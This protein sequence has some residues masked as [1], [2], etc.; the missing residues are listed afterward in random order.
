MVDTIYTIEQ[1]AD[2][3]HIKP[4][5]LREWIRQEKVKAFKLGGLVR[6]HEKDLQKFIDSARK[7]TRKKE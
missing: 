2:I 6:I 1:A 7:N 3:L 5:T 4:R